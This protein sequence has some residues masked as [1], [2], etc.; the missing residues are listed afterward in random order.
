LVFFNIVLRN[1]GPAI[2][3][4]IVW[5]KS[6]YCIQYINIYTGDNMGHTQSIHILCKQKLAWLKLLGIPLLFLHVQVR[7]F[8]HCGI[9]SPRDPEDIWRGNASRWHIQIILWLVHTHVEHLMSLPCV[10]C[11]HRRPFLPTLHNLLMC[12]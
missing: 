5:T 1:G 11:L 10:V 12:R 3:D 7:I 9:K 4:C 8:V 2:S 6:D